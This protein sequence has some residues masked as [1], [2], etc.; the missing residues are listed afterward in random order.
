M[1]NET[2]VNSDMP[3]EPETPQTSVEPQLRKPPKWSYY[4]RRDGFYRLDENSGDYI[5]INGQNYTFNTAITEG[6]VF[7]TEDNS[8]FRMNNSNQR[9]MISNDNCRWITVKDD[10]VYYCND[11]GVCRVRF[12]GGGK[13]QLVQVNCNGL[14]LT[15]DYIFYILHV[16]DDTKNHPGA[17]DGPRPWLG[18]LHRVDYNG[19][20]DLNLDVLVN[21]FCVH[22]NALYFAD[23]GDDYF[24][25]MNPASGEKEVFY[26]GHFIEDSCF[27]DGY[28]YFTSDRS[29]HKVSLSDGTVE[30]FTEFFW[31]RCNGILDGYVYIDVSNE[32]PSG[33]G[34]YR[35]EVN[36]TAFELVDSY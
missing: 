24:Y 13:E 21:D 23:A 35:M 30:R 10:W 18:Q 31:P 20:N 32:A 25:K 17:D 5:R 7:Y 1:T 2:P 12:D 16:E 4:F 26:K 34:L 28:V 14:A 22:D 19:E 9:E 6:W 3:I 36:G 29:L 33:P 8:L 11:T 27:S 15:E